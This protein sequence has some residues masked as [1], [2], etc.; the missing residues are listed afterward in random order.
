MR[1]GRAKYLQL[2]AGLHGRGAP[3][4]A[5]AQAAVR[6]ALPPS[7]TPRT[8]RPSRWAMVTDGDGATAGRRKSSPDPPD[9]H[10]A[11]TGK[12]GDGW[13]RAVAAGSA[14]S[15]AVRA[16]RRSMGCAL[17]FSRLSSARERKK[18]R[19]IYNFHGNNKQS[20]SLGILI[21]K[22]DRYLR[23]KYKRGN[24]TASHITCVAC[25]VWC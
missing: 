20:S 23:N 15:E 18:I 1:R 11:T 16:R 25:S 21:S 19:L 24:I 5:T 3:P 12:T 9:P 2:E 14:G 4:P 10:E 6:S 17:R 7:L 13:I 22:S 8:G